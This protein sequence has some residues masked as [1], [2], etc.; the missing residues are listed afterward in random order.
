MV[1]KAEVSAPL[2]A[3]RLTIEC[4]VFSV[5]ADKLAVLLTKRATEPFAGLWSLPTG[6]L[7]YNEPLERACNR[8]LEAETGLTS[9]RFEQLGAVGTPGRDP[10]GHTV[11]IVY[12]SFMWAERV[13]LVPG[14]DS[15][16]ARF[17]PVDRIGAH[18]LA[19]GKAPKKQAA[20]ELAFDHKWLVDV[21]HRRLADRLRDPSV[22]PRF[23][24]VPSQ[25]T[26]SQLQRVHELIG[27]VSLTSRTFRADLLASGAVEPVAEGKT[28]R[29]RLY[30]WRS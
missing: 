2:R 29:N 7:S 1:L 15:L 11:S 30:R 28:S 27:G 16:E 4:V 6:T 5:R 22:A 8:V 24:F 3:P 26:L 9:V 14:A 19:S 25:F 10:R 21:A 13:R 20:V 12:Y 18:V 17:Q 23:E